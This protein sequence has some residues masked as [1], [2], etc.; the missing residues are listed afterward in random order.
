MEK[1]MNSADGV[2]IIDKPAGWTSHDVVAKIRNLTRVRKVGHTGTLD[3]FATGVLPLTLG[4]ATR[5]TNYFQAS[6]KV[7]RGVMRF[8]FAT[9]TYDVD[10]RPLG[11]D[12]RPELDRDRLEEILG[13]YRGPLRQAPPPSPPRNSR[14]NPCTPMRA[15]GSR[16]PPRP[17]KSPSARSNWSPSTGAR[18]SSSSPV[19][20]APMPGAWR[21]ISGRSTAAARISSACAAPKAASSPSRTPSSW[22]RKRAR[23]SNTTRAISSSAASSPSAACSGRSPPSCSPTATGRSSS[24][25]PT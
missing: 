14:G 16:S 22:G 10:G 17:R 2:L 21:T 7:Y 5:L 6:D 18:R 15:P 25:G 9:D 11:E 20:R 3:P 19:P 1:T 23:G 13:R 4:R 24:T 12:T 8:G